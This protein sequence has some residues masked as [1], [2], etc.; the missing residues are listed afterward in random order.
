MTRTRLLLLRWS[1]RHPLASDLLTATALIVT[2]WAGMVVLD[3]LAQTW[4]YAEM[5][6]WAP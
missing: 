4:Q 3:L 1:Q 2:F 5:I 6:G